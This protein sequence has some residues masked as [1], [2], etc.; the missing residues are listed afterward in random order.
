MGEAT[1]QS[2]GRPKLER[3]QAQ[4]KSRKPSEGPDRS[5]KHREQGAGDLKAPKRHPRGTQEAPME[6][7]ESRQRTEEPQDTE[8]HETCFG[9]SQ[10][11][12]RMASH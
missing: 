7:H 1:R 8:Q 9:E 2:L 3:R 11:K 10:Q 4:G 12:A 5:R 6:G